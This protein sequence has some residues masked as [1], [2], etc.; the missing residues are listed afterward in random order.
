MLSSFFS[1][2]SIKQGKTEKI[3]KSLNFCLHLTTEKCNIRA[4]ADTKNIKKY[5]IYSLCVRVLLG[6]VRLR[7]EENAGSI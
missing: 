2:T 1:L 7:R 4:P 3:L 5:T 6:L